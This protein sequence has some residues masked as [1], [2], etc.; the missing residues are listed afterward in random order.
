M[1]QLMPESRLGQLLD[2]LLGTDGWRDLTLPR[3]R[4]TAG[5]HWIA[6]RQ[7][8]DGRWGADVR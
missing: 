1:K 8:P 4:L 3:M 6:V 2:E 5:T 7:Q